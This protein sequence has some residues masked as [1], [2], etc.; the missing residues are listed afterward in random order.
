MPGLALTVHSMNYHCIFTSF[1]L[2]YRLFSCWNF[3]HSLWSKDTFSP[4]P[5][6]PSDPN[7]KFP[8][9]RQPS[10][11]TSGATSLL[12]Q[13]PGELCLFPSCFISDSMCVSGCAQQYIPTWW[14][15]LE[16]IQQSF[17]RNAMRIELNFSIIFEIVGSAGY[18][19]ISFGDDL[20]L[21]MYK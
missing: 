15:C 1:I 12:F 4:T 21:L 18:F 19:F 3:P 10:L 5:T 6:H 8:S 13:A 2:P 17:W 7:S 20:A 11:A 16:H 14:W 9:S